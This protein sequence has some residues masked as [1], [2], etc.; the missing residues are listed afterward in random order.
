MEVCLCNEVLWFKGTTTVQHFISKRYII[1]VPS[2][3]IAV[4]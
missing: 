3:T 4:F 1:G 2:V